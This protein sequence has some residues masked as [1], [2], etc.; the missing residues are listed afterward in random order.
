M[1]ENELENKKHVRS[2][3]ANSTELVLPEKVTGTEIVK[4]FPSF[5]GTPRFITSFTSVRDLSL[6]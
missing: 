1:H 3:T 5:Y 2:L 4:K 6:Y